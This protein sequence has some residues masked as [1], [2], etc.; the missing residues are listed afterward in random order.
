MCPSCSSSR[1][2]WEVS[3]GSG[4]L[5]TWTVVHQ[6]LHPAFAQEVPYA[7]VVVQLDEGPRVVSRLHDVPI[8]RLT[9][10]LRLEVEFETVGADIA[11]PWF[12]PA[13]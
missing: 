11:L 10:G 7:L 6:A 8:E 4:A 2:S 12:H 13:G 1:W 9:V 5:Y 3:S